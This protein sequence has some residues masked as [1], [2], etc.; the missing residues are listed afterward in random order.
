MC[1]RN[2]LVGEV[3]LVVNGAALAIRSSSLISS[4]SPCSA[5]A[6][7]AGDASRIAPGRP[8]EAGLLRLRLH[9]ARPELLGQ[10]TGELGQLRAFR[11][12]FGFCA[13]VAC[14][15][16]LS[17]NASFGKLTLLGRAT[18][19]FAYVLKSRLERRC[20]VDEHGLLAHGR[21][22]RHKSLD[23]TAVVSWFAGVDASAMKFSAPS[24]FF[25]D[26]L[27]TTVAHPP[28]VDAAPREPGRSRSARAPRQ[29][30]CLR[31]PMVPRTSEPPRPLGT[32]LSRW[33]S[34]ACPASSAAEAGRPRRRGTTGTSE[35]P[36]PSGT[37]PGKTRALP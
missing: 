13:K 10:P 1:R 23:P 26:A 19:Y 17:A 8:G 25:F 24:T 37:S 28:R 29:P 14:P 7:E 6:L 4:P 5:A 33:R 36:G 31:P 12:A 35:H 21:G 32:S 30:P 11:L 27:A 20:E 15:T 2:F 34:P 22:R 18:P 3:E 16:G 9:A